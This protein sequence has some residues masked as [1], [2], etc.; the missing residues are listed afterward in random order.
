[1]ENNMA[2]NLK[3]KELVN[4]KLANNYGGWIYC[5]S[6]NQTI[7]YL[8]YV[9]Y[10]S[11]ALEYSCNCGNK[12]KIDIEKEELIKAVPSMKNLI[13]VKNR[14]CCPEDQSPLITILNQKLKDSSCKIVCVNCN[15]E[16]SI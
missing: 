6:C 10:H 13:I 15:H 2:Q 14:L 16:Y 7:G 5:S 12:G 4:T 11:I 8:C 9:T 3:K 1:M